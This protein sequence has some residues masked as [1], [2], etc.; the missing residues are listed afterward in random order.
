MNKKIFP[1]VAIISSILSA[2]FVL[3]DNPVEH[4]NKALNTFFE[5]YPQEKVYIQFDK[6]HY[7]IGDTIWYKGYVT[8]K[9]SPSSI[10]K[11]LYVEIV[12]GSGKI[13]K[14]QTLPVEE[15]GAEG[16]FVAGGE[17]LPGNYYVRSYTA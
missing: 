16:D 4:I 17:M 5:K 1:A 9:N 13:L 8:Y 6:Q 2:S 15:G 7:T 10:S 11:I 12:D 3:S 14:R